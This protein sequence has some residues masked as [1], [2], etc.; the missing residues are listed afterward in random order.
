MAVR[1]AYARPRSAAG[2]L[3][4]YSWLFMRLSGLLL[5]FLALGHLAIMHLIHSV[6]EIDYDFVA[7]RLAG[8]LGVFWRLYD[9]L[10]LTLAL[11]HG[12]NGLRVVIDDY[13]H[14]PRWRAVSLTALYVAGAFILVLGAV[15]LFTFQPQLGS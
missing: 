3:E 10:L 9:L 14:T 11:L 15:V 7:A 12:L 6:E 8:P 5:V 2:G 13:V 4:L 1:P